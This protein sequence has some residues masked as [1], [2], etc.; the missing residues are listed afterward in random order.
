[1][2]AGIY[3]LSFSIS[4]I[5]TIFAESNIRRSVLDKKMA[6]AEEYIKEANLPDNLKI[7]FQQSIRT[8]AERKCFSA[9]DK[10]DMLNEFPKQLRYEIAT[11]MHLYALSRI[12]F[13]REKDSKFIADIV[14]YMQPYYVPK[15]ELVTSV[16]EIA[17]NI[18]FII[19]GSANYI[20]GED[21]IP[22]FHIKTGHSFGDFESIHRLTRTNNIIAA[23]NLHL[24][25][26]SLKVKYN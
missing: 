17:D 20:Y 22:F 21:N 5:S 24:L 10:H 19:Q 9:E 14:S 6:I 25:A 26:L 4:S 23:N 7:K 2:I 13:F 12:E 15:K 8:K 11:T 1:M 16:G 3:F 18:F